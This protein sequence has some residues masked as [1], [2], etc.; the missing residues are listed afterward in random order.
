MLDQPIPEGLHTATPY[1]IVRGAE[2][3]LGFLEA[4]FDAELRARYDR[5]DGGIMHAQVRI[6]DS[7]IEL[8]EATDTYPPMPGA[9]HLYVPDVDVSFSR[10]VAAGAVARQA[11]MDHDYGERG[12]DVEDP[13]GNRWFLATLTT[14]TAGSGA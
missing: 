5:P 12:A 1:L 13:T 2:R 4:A 11:P 3:L 7:T 8:A 9:I 14:T 6:G 10:A